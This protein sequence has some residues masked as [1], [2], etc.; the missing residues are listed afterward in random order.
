MKSGK[1]PLPKDQLNERV[2][3]GLW[4]SEKVFV[5]FEGLIKY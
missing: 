3:K 5:Y 4:R 2:E 1:F